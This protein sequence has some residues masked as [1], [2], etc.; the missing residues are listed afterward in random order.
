MR[1]Q[2]DQYLSKLPSNPELFSIYDILCISNIPASARNF[3]RTLSRVL[4]NRLT[5]IRKLMQLTE[6]LVI[7]LIIKKINYKRLCCGLN[8]PKKTMRPD[9]PS[10]VNFKMF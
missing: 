9:T 6:N 2:T 1:I 10:L 7:H 3:Y 5:G 4:L 8:R